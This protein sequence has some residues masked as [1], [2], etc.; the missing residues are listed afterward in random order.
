MTKVLTTRLETKTALRIEKAAS[1]AHMD[2]TSFMRI[3]L[4][5]GLSS[6]EEEKFLKRY[7]SEEISLGKLA[8]ALSITK[9]DAHELLRRK[10][11]VMPYSMEDLED[12]TSIL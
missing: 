6:F 9:W 12:D 3:I 8:D 2:K 7:Q 10:G 1:D 4:E 5:K 11:T